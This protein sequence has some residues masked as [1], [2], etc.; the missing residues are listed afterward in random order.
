MPI[1]RDENSKLR[2]SVPK[3]EIML[4]TLMYK[5]KNEEELEWVYEQIT[6]ATDVMYEEV[7]E[8]IDGDE[9]IE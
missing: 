4:D 8:S 1:I 6:S 5:A 9:T 2:V 7:L 3:L